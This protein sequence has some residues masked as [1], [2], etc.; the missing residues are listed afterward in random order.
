MGKIIVKGIKLYAYHGCTDEEQKI[1]TNYEV[2]VTIDA[3]LDKASE[4]DN[5][6]DTIDYVIVYV[7]VKEQ[8][9]IK[10]ILIEHVAKRIIDQLLF[11]LPTIEKVKVRVSKISPPINGI[12][13]GVCVELE[14]TRK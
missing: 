10:S 6:N 5:L 4:S 3:N 12:L 13:D 8:M 14:E 9:A 2:D 1:G 11:K 7:I